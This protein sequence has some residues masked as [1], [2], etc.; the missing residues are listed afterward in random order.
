MC[1]LYSITLTRCAIFTPSPLQDVPFCPRHIH[2]MCQLVLP[3]S[4]SQ[5]LPSLLHHPHKMCHLAR[6]TLTRCAILLPSPSQ[7]VPSCPLHL[8]RACRLTPSSRKGL[9]AAPSLFNPLRHPALLLHTTGSVVSP[10]P[11]QGPPS[12][13][14]TVIGNSPC[15]VLAFRG[16]TGP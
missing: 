15:A 13:S 6:F 12:G 16:T 7:A 10:S 9:S 5:D 3:P 2:K 14:L 4:P 11:P 8:I 1:H